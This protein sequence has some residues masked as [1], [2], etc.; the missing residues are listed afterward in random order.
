L[1][2][3]R[4]WNAIPSPRAGR[5][6]GGAMTPSRI[7]CGLAGLAVV[8][9]LAVFFFPATQGPYSVVH[10]PV[11]VMHAA[12]AAAGVRMGVNRAGLNCVRRR[13]RAALV[14]LPCAA[15]RA[16]EFRSSASAT[17]AGITLR[18]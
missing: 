17:A 9:V 16:A 3:M 2:V 5:D 10:G 8:C 14:L 18:C 11:T 1:K 7:A 15:G 13:V 6:A 4:Q 12:R